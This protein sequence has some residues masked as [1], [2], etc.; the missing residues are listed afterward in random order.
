ME[1]KNGYKAEK[2]N[3]NFSTD[4]WLGLYMGAVLVNIFATVMRIPLPYLLDDSFMTGIVTALLSIIQVF[5][6]IFLMVAAYSKAILVFVNTLSLDGKQFSTKL[7]YN[8]IFSVILANILLSIFTIGIYI[9]WGYKAIID[10][11]IENTEYEGSKCFKFSSYAS[12]LFSFIVISIVVMFVLAFVLVLSFVI[13]FN[14]GGV[15]GIMFFPI[16]M[17]LLISFVATACAMQVFTINWAINLKMTS[18]RKNATYSLNINI[19]S[20]ILFY[21]GQTMLLMITLGFYVG[22]YMINIYE[23]FISR[24]IEKTNENITG[25]LRFV[26]P[27][28]KGAGFLLGQVIL[29]HITAGFYSPFA[30]VEYSRFFI[31]NTYLDT[32]EKKEE[33]EVNTIIINP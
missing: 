2:F 22:A 32:I 9:P 4:G 33:E 30:L 27:V 28:G 31:N 11:I 7:D 19:S 20:A 12:Q 10:K 21:L 5:A 6:M 16:M 14:N 25:H 18:D 24:T 3:T 26:K 8:S 23:Y 29:T 17:V 15:I 13:V 1:V